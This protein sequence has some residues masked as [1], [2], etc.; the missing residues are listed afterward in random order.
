MLDFLRFYVM[1][2]VY[3]AGAVFAI[4]A[5]VALIEI[6]FG[7]NARPKVRVRRET[8]S[9]LVL[10]TPSKLDGCASTPDRFGTKH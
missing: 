5:V 1:A 8:L 10:E 6:V 9:S 3:I 2:G 7:L 4:S